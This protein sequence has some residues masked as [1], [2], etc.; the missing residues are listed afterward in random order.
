MTSHVS[1]YNGLVAKA[2]VLQYPP[3]SPDLAP[4]DF[5]L[6]GPFKTFLSGKRFEDQIHCKKQLCSTAHPL[7]KY[8]TVK[9]CLNL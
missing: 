8:S 4:S 3:H 2:K 9:E 6:F 5:Y 1:P 7:E